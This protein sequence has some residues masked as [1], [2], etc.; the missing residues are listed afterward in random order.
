MPTQT[1]I[2][3]D[4]FASA[5]WSGDDISAL[6][7][8]TAASSKQTNNQSSTQDDNNDDDDQGNTGNQNQA[9]NADKLNAQIDK[10][11]AG[12]DLDD[13]DED[14]QDNQDDDDDQNNSDSGQAQGATKQAPAKQGDTSRKGRKPT[15]LVS[16]VSKLVEEDVLAGFQDSAEIKTNEEAIEL[17]KLNLKQ[18]EEEATENAFKN[19]VKG[20]SPQVQTILHYA[21]QGAQSATEIM[22]LMGAMKEMEELYDFDTSDTNGQEAIVRQYYKSKGFKDNYIDKQLTLIKDAGKENLK[23]E[24]EAFLPELLA[25]NEKRIQEKI[26]QQEANKKRAEEASRAYIS[27]VKSTL[28]AGDKMEEVPIGKEDKAKVFEAIANPKYNSLS[29]MPTTQFVKTLED[30][31]F[32]ENKNYAHFLNVVRYTIDPKG[33]VNSLKQS[34]ENN[35]AATTQRTLRQTKTSSPTSAE[36]VAGNNNNTSKKTIK[37]DFVNP[38]V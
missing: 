2:L 4:E 31:Q 13:D 5:L 38:F 29:G 34:L 23:E 18:R 6:T 19:K 7:H 35:I 12:D 37:K 1:E 32:G 16:A 36:P 3:T 22:Q 27:T 14:D 11:F 25:D 33:F 8:G 10:I 20:Y 15:D 24:A 21:E 17:L 30:L 26:R 28:T 9:P